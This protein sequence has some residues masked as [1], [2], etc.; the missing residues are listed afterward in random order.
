[1]NVVLLTA[2]PKWYQTID[3]LGKIYLGA[4]V[5]PDGTNGFGDTWAKR[6]WTLRN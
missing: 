4:F 1:V 6:W 5:D 3:S 2:V